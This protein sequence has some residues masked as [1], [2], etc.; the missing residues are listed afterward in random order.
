MMK[1]IM[2]TNFIVKWYKVKLQSLK[3][4]IGLKYHT[5][6]ISKPC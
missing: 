4:Y 2:S 1:T 6:R 5:G 3:I